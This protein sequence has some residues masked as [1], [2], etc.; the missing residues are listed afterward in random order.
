MRT[1]R[2]AAHLCAAF[3]FLLAGCA[4]PL[5]IGGSRESVEAWAVQRGFRTEMLESGRFQLYALLRGTAASGALTLYLEG[6]G[7]P[8]PNPY[9]PPR[10]PTP[11]RPVALLLAERDPSPA[12]AYLG[13]PC[14][15]LEDA[16]RAQCGPAYW[17]SRRFTPE[18]LAAM[19]D[20]VSRLKQSAGAK[21]LRLVG[22]SGGGVIAALLA[23]RRSDVDSLITVAAPLSLNAWIAGHDLS[24]LEDAL[25]PQQLAIQSGLP[26]A[27]HFAGA[28]DDI[29][30][31]AIVAEFVGR[32]GGR[33]ETIADFDHDCCWVRDWPVLLGRAR[34]SEGRP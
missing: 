27:R 14:Q 29:V 4:A 31:A 12:V 9:R 6:D 7:A 30:P 17:S 23:M 18:V 24:A 32:H 28:E 34:A 5:S 10:D 16:A 21:R 2:K 20:A 13:R 19:D 22:H 25:D 26:P 33:L 11:I 3:C 1:G 8:W 15:Y